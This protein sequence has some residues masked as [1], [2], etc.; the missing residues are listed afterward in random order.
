MNNLKKDIYS[1][2]VIMLIGILFSCTKNPASLS[3]SEKDIFGKWEWY[4]TIN[5][6]PPYTS[7]PQIAGFT[8]Y[9]SFFKDSTYLKYKNN[10]IIEQGSF[11]TKSYTG[12]QG[13]V[14]KIISFNDGTRI[15]DYSNLSSHQDTLI[16]RY[17]ATDTPYEKFFRVK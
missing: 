2:L 14:Y 9:Y 7:T 11:S 5:V 3:I 6:F 12:F 13:E 8:K 1:L 15:S 17:N 4:M 16:L 10:E